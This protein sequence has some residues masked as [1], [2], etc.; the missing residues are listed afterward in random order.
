MMRGLNDLAAMPPDH[1]K[2]LRLNHGPTL[3][4]LLVL[5]GLGF[6]AFRVFEPFLVAGV[7]A[8]VIVVSS[9]HGLLALQ[10]R[11]GGRRWAAVTVLT[12]AL[13]LLLV[14]PLT[15]AV[16]AAVVNAGEIA[17]R[18][19]QLSGLKLPPP[20]AW[21]SALPLVGPRLVLLWEQWAAAG[22]EGLLAQLT[23]YAGAVTK[24]VLT[25][26][27]GF[28]FI[29]FECLMALAF[30]ALLYARGEE[31]A[32]L[33]RRLGR[34]LAGHTGLA[35]VTLTTQ[36][37]RGVALGVGGTAVVQALMAGAGLALAGVPFVWLLTGLTFVLCIAQL[38]TPLV[39]VPAVIWLYWSGDTGWGTVLLVWAVIIGTADN[40]IRPI[41]IQRGV[42]LP[43]WLVFTGV[44]G[45]LLAFGLVG[46][47]VGPVVLAVISM[48]VMQWLDGEAAAHGGAKADTEAAHAPPSELRPLHHRDTP[49]GA[50]AAAPAPLRGPPPAG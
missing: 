24:R 26:A 13:L 18:V 30:A 20:P 7:W 46:V 5:A 32:E 19:K 48:L 17:D 42:D 34:R 8:V 49:A 2:P 4:G 44:V 43:F 15:L 35:A 39:M 41:L 11:L 21:V 3:A 6:A 31:A 16:S 25:E 1:Q 14:V 36:A 40:V 50:P 23:P 10:A 22:L 33:A 29:L 37:I 45:G 12:L 28:G 27:S 9:W 38:G 47:F